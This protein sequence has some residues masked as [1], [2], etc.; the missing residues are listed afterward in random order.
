MRSCWK[1]QA[2]ARFCFDSC[3]ESAASS[4]YV[5]PGQAC[6]L[7]WIQAPGEPHEAPP[8]CVALGGMQ[9][10]PSG[11]SHTV[12]AGFFSGSGV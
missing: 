1:Q 7:L 11:D 10:T 3:S 6:A 5:Q 4:R 12:S 9:T 2:V 8:P